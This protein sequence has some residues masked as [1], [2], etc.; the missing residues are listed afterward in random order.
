MKF[1]SARNRRI[2]ARA[3][4]EISC[5]WGVDCEM[6]PPMSPV[7][8]RVFRDGLLVALAEFKRREIF[9]NQYP[10]VFLSEMKYDAM[11]EASEHHAVP[12]YYVI[13]FI[14]QTRSIDISR[15]DI[16]GKSVCGRDPRPGSTHDQEVIIEIPIKEMKEIVFS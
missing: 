3:A 12:A 10:T 11:K 7:D 9:H 14:D 6:Q 15:V 1:E 8:W 2:E 13:E 16:S 5:A 4:F